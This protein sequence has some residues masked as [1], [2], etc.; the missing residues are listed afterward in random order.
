MVVANPEIQQSDAEKVDTRSAYFSPRRMVEELK[1][2]N[3]QQFSVKEI[4]VAMG[5]LG[6]GSGYIKQ[7]HKTHAPTRVR[8]GDAV[9]RVTDDPLYQHHDTMKHELLAEGI[10]DAAEAANHVLKHGIPRRIFDISQL[11]SPMEYVWLQNPHKEEQEKQVSGYIHGLTREV[12]EHNRAAAQLED[13]KDHPDQLVAEMIKQIGAFRQLEMN[14]EKIE[15]HGAE[16]YQTKAEFQA[17]TDEIAQ[18]QQQTQALKEALK[19]HQWD[20]ADTIIEKEWIC[21]D[22]TGEW[23]LPGLKTLNRHPEPM[24]NVQQAL[25]GHHKRLVERD[26]FAL[27]AFA[28]QLEEA[29][30]HLDH[31]DFN[32]ALASFKQ[33]RAGNDFSQIEDALGDMADFADTQQT[34]YWQ[35]VARLS[36]AVSKRMERKM[37]TP[38]LSSLAVPADSFL[39]K[40]KSESSDNLEINR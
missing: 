33:G 21:K 18:R 27:I 35:Q 37:Q 8:H 19:A 4:I 9:A 20:Q 1:N 14:N 2:R 6:A 15:L 22:T 34:P 38:S 23:P 39:R 31:P 24:R 3:W 17:F 29:A 13:A 30:Q 12:L 25:P 40:L 16:N 7:A 28:K 5:I 10:T 26:S 11:S 32:A 36:D